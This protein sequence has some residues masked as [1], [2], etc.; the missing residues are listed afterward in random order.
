MGG[1]G[2]GLAFFS[3]ILKIILSIQSSK[4]QNMEIQKF[5]YFFFVQYF[6]RTPQIR[7]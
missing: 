1:E 4:H 6:L 2:D 3:I 5:H 7:F